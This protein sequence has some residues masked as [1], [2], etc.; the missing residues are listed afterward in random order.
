MKNVLARACKKLQPARHAEI[1]LLTLK[2]QDNTKIEF[3]L[4]M[5]SISATSFRNESFKRGKC[6]EPLDMQEFYRISELQN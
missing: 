1:C 3:P 5:L 6:G 2:E 4:D